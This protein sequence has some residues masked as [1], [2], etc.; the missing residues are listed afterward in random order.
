[1][2]GVAVLHRAWSGDCNAEMEQT[3]SSDGGYK[4]EAIVYDLL[5]ALG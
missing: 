3:T 4:Q 5:V 2:R 1:M